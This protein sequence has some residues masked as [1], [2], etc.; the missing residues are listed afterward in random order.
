MNRFATLILSTLFF[1]TASAQNSKHLSKLTHKI[2]LSD[3][4]V[5]GAHLGI[6]IYEPETNSYVY[7]Y[8]AEKNFIPASNTKFFTLY[9]GMKY[10]GNNIV[11]AYYKISNDTIFLL[12]TGDPTYLHPD[13]SI[14]PVHDFLNN[15]NYKV[16]ML[17]DERYPVP[18]GKGWAWDDQQEDYMPQRSS[19]PGCGN[20]LKLEWIKN[21]NAKPNQF[22]YDLAVMNTDVP[23]FSITKKTDTSLS[24]NFIKRTPGTNHFEVIVNNKLQAFTQEIPVETKGLASG[25]MTLQNSLYRLASLQKASN[26]N[27]KDFIPYFSQKS[28][29]VFSLMMKRSDNFYAEQTLLMTANEKLGHFNEQDMIDS[30]LQH[31]FAAIPQRPRWVDGSGLSRYN[32]FSPN[33]LV[34]II[35]KIQTEFGEERLKSIL[36]T[37]GIGT[38]KNYFNADSSFIYAKTGSLSNNYSLCGLLTTKKNKPLIFAVMLNNYVGSSKGVRKLIE[39]YLHELREKN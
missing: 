3:S 22:Q 29:A 4:I 19:F 21:D 28:D 17:D 30:L 25:F 37:G 12:P 1:V 23:E 20:L 7:T 32:L 24:Y 14:H 15:N 34:Y 36:P 33:D 16:V 35:N 5:N 10:L 9:A 2:L 11:G 13:Y 8:N 31:D 26:I 6:S 18:Y 38:L 27:R 39:A